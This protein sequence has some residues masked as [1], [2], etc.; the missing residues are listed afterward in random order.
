MVNGVRIIAMDKYE[1]RRQR[2]LYI[3]D[4]LCGGKAVDVART[5]GR[6][7]SYVSGCST[8]KAKAKER[9]ADEMVELI[10]SSFNLPR[11]WMDG[12]TGNIDIEREPVED[13]PQ[14]PYVIE[15]LMPVPAQG[16]AALSPVRLMKR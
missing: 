16:R 3:R 7:P 9:I 4:N 1:I 12:I 6:E 5:L 8:P 10:E 14:M 11:G 2:L 13:S 15:V